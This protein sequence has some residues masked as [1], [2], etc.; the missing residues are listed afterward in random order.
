MSDESDPIQVAIERLDGVAADAAWI[1]VDAGPDGDLSVRGNAA[2]LARLALVLLKCSQDSSGAREYRSCGG[3]DAD[4]EALRRPTPAG[5]TIEAIE[6]L[7]NPPA[8][9]EGDEKRAQLRDR[10]F[11]LGC[12]AIVFVVGMLVLA[13]LGV[14]TGVIQTVR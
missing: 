8:E 9:V 14:V 2:G 13:G 4:L 3:A 10:L 12:G 11:L 1:A 5:V 6:L 7:Q